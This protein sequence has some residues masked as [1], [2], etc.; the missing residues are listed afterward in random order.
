MKKVIFKKKES[1]TICFKD[2][3]ERHIILATKG[4]KIYQLHELHDRSGIAFQWC[5][6]G[7]ACCWGGSIEGGVA[8][9]LK[10]ACGLGYEALIFDSPIEM[11]EY[12]ADF[13]RDKEC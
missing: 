9:A 8:D 6:V 1:D 2:V 7:D 13:Y 4:K 12:I 5:D 10:S 11:A 3:T